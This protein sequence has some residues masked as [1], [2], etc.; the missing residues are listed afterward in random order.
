MHYL[1]DTLKDFLDMDS[2]MKW[3]KVTGQGFCLF[4][5][6]RSTNIEIICPSTK[7][8]VKSALET[9]RQESTFKNW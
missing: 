9:G 7:H 4:F 1:C 3:S 5:Y 2:R 8:V 6:P